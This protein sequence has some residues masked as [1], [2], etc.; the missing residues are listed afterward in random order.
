MVLASECGSVDCPSEYPDWGSGVPGDSGS[1][2][3]GDSGSNPGNAGEDEATGQFRL[4]TTDH[5]NYALNLN[6]SNLLSEVEEVMR[7]PS[8]DD[9]SVHQPLNKM[10]CSY[11]PQWRDQNTQ[12]LIGRPSGTTT[13]SVTTV[14]IRLPDKYFGMFLAYGQDQYGISPHVMMGLAAKETFATALYPEKDNSYFIVDKEDDHFNT[15]SNDSLFIDGNKD[16]PFQV[17]TPA[18]STDVSVLPQRFYFGDSSTPVRD[19]KPKYVSDNELLTDYNAFRAYHDSMTGD[20]YKAIV[21]SC[22]D[23]HFR[24]NIVMQMTKQGMRP[25]WDLR[26]GNEEAEDALEFAGVMYTYN[27]GLWSMMDTSKC[28]VDKNPIT[29]CKLDGYGGHSTDINN[30][31]QLLNGA[32]EVYDFW[33]SLEDVLW[34]VDKLHETY[35]YDSVVGIHDSIDWSGMRSK[36]R[37]VY[38]VILSHRKAKDSSARGISF[39]YDW[40]LLLAVI[41]AYLPKKEEFYGPTLENMVKWSFMSAIAPEAHAWSELPSSRLRDYLKRYG[42]VYDGRDVVPT[43]VPTV[44]PTV[45]PTTPSSC[46]NGVCEEGETVANCPADCKTYPERPLDPPSCT[47]KENGPQCYPSNCCDQYYVCLNGRVFGPSNLPS[48]TVCY[49]GSQISASDSRC[50]GVTCEKSIPASCGD[51]VCA[52]YESCSSC[53]KD[54]GECSEV[55][56]TPLPEPTCG[57]GDI[58]FQCYPHNC[59]GYVY[60]CVY[61]SMSPVYS[62][63]DGG[64]CYNGNIVD[65]NVDVCRD[66]DCGGVPSEYCG[67]GVCDGNEDCENCPEDCGACPTVKPTSAPTVKPTTAPTVKPTTA[68]TVK[69]TIKPTTAPTTSPSTPKLLVGYYTNWSQY[70]GGTSQYF[71]ENIDPT[72]FTHLVYAFA[73]IAR[74]TWQVEQVEWNDVNEWNP[75][76]GLYHRFNKHIRAKNPKC[77]TLLAFGGWNFNFKEEFKDIFTTMAES[78]SNRATCINSMISWVRKH[79][80]D[81]IDVDWE[82]PGWEELGGRPQDKENFVSFVQELRAAIDAEASRTGKTRLLLTLAVAAGYDKIDTGYDIPRIRDYVDYVSVMAYD[83]HGQWET[84]TGAASGLYPPSE[85]EPGSIDEYYTGDYAIQYWISKGMPREK[86]VMGLAAYGR[87]WTLESSAPGQTLGAPAIRGCDPMKDTQQEGVLNYIEALTVINSGGVTTFDATTTTMYVQKGDQWYSYEDPNSIVYK[88]EYIKSENLL[89]G[90]LWAVDNDDF[91]N[92]N[93]MISSIYNSLYSGG[94][95]GRGVG[96]KMVVPSLIVGV[97]VIV[98]VAT[99]AVVVVNRRRHPRMRVVRSGPKALKKESRV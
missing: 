74:D 92:G 32:R 69:P 52:I 86:I 27:R 29:D 17:E 6:P 25:G 23:L 90:M 67:N 5:G 24:H 14:K 34:F 77:K 10:G 2:S 53:P 45:K 44:K 36:V 18:M 1:D 30:V 47:D 21:L 37:E 63:L 61:G 66:V 11:H 96:G 33:I 4:K 85:Y 3:G 68:P 7:I 48:G 65:K 39:R 15:L 19:R 83:L 91:R 98:V 13:V 26:N 87:G 70:R 80:F 89:G 28:T 81:G 56:P 40:R 97:V 57:V 99:I 76:Q 16:G 60:Q 22:L 59:C 20:F 82:Y 78:A 62:I 84:K 43:S 12:M 88:V 93:P 54:C 9:A 94:K 95:S 41:R 73:Y 58:G 51:G 49:D 75:T 46:G 72:K 8:Y 55:K 71:P 31:C 50:M 79:D 35:P 64:V 42:S 38:P